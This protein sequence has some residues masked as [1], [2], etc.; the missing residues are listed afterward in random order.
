MGKTISQINKQFYNNYADSWD[1]T[2]QGFWKGWQIYWNKVIS[3]NNNIFIEK[4][5]RKK[6]VNIL[7]IGCGNGRLGS[8]YFQKFQ[9]IDS[10]LKLNYWGV[11]ISENLLKIAEKQL[12]KKYDSLNIKCIDIAKIDKFTKYLQTQDHSFDLIN[13]IALAHHL[14]PN[15]F[16]NLL[17]LSFDYLQANGF[18]IFTKWN[19][20]FSEKIK[21]KIIKNKNTINK[22]IDKK[23]KLN[24]NDYF[25]DWKADKNKKQFLRFVHWYSDEEVLKIIKKIKLNKKIKINLRFSFSA[26]GNNDKLNK[27]YLLQKSI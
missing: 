5:K 18:I 22:I 1:N 10:N 23:I 15:D 13:I 26:D 4:I 16:E 2:R 27:Y 19:F 8:F 25:L 6:N 9:E 12:N 11:D 14:K 17:K 24:K 7:D 21:R 3:I 20:L